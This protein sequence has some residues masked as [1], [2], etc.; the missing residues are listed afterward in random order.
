MF[1]VG[2]C[3]RMR[4]RARAYERVRARV[5]VVFI[6][7]LMKTLSSNQFYNEAIRLLTFLKNADEQIPNLFLNALRK[8]RY[9]HIEYS[10][11]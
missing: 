1:G 2:G 11:I 7:L 6:F 8:Y 5:R 3:V 10:C 9:N 4:E